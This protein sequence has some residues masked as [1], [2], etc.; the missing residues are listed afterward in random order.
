[1]I[2][3]QTLLGIK[4]FEQFKQ[5][6][7]LIDQE[8]IGAKLVLLIDW[9]IRDLCSIYCS[10]E[11]KDMLMNYLVEI[12]ESDDSLRAKIGCSPIKLFVENGKLISAKH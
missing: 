11:E 5:E 6:E 9:I 3:P 1:M 12:A 2:H 8:Y 10:Q 4:A 7:R